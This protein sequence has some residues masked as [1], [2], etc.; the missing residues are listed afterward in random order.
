MFVFSLSRCAQCHAHVIEGEYVEYV[1]GRIWHKDC[2]PEEHR[3]ETCKQPIFGEITNA[4][5]KE[6]HPKCFQCGKCQKHL[7]GSYVNYHVRGKTVVK[8]KKRTK[9]IVQGAPYCKPCADESKANV[10]KT[11]VSNPNDPSVKLREANNA[12]AVERQGELADLQKFEHVAI[13]DICA[14]CSQE[15]LVDPYFFLSLAQLI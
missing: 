13:G 15:I 4:I 8:K 7:D 2:F 14:K 12:K 9:I 10:Q 11:Q 3:C 5:G 6:Y 1:D